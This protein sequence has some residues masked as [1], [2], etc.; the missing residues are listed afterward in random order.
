MVSTV[1][2]LV[3]A[4]HILFAPFCFA[5]M[6]AGW[7]QDMQVLEGIVVPFVLMSASFDF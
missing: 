2:S 3:W 7:S 4:Y 6:R 1:M 5:E